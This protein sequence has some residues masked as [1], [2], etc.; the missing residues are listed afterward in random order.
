MTRSGFLRLAAF[1]C[2]AW[3]P[4]TGCETVNEGWQSVK[5]TVSGFDLGFSR[6]QQ[7]QQ[8]QPAGTAET[9]Q[10]YGPEST[11]A[12]EKETLDSAAPASAIVDAPQQVATTP[13]ADQPC[14]KVSVVEELNM[15][16]RFRMD[17]GGRD[18]LLDAHITGVNSTCQYKDGDIAIDLDI[19]FTETG[20]AAALST[21]IEKSLTTYPYFVAVTTN[22]GT[23]KAKQAYSVMILWA[24]GKDQ[25]TQTDRVR[26]VISLNGRPASGYRIMVGF[27][28]TPDEL[29]YTRNR[30]LTA[31]GAPVP[32]TPPSP[33]GQAAPTVQETV[34]EMG[35]ETPP[36]GTESEPLHKHSVSPADDFNMHVPAAGE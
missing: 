21:D 8:E 17:S 36:A 19:T 31:A 27:Q 18:L 9:A 6:P 33:A 10:A 35:K 16:P 26:Q 5:N 28:L 24:K 25:I 11:R 34:Q 23:I 20:S 7:Q 13:A 22:D 2:I 32:V 4:L 30:P 14:P 3:L 12:V 29:A 1:A 15:L